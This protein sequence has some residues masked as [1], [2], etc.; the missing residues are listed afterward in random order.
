MPIDRQ[1]QIEA[2]EMH[3]GKG[4]HCT[5]VVSRSVEHHADNSTVWLIFIPILRNKLFGR[6]HGTPTTLPLP[7][8]LRED[9]RQE[10]YLEYPHAGKAL[11][12]YK[13][14]CFFQGSNPGPTA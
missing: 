13:Y 14:P 10:G 11:C 6:G 5:D 1:C 8:T 12:I 3:Q 9:L 7:P 2:Q 4:L